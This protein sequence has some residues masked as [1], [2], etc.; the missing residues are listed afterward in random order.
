[1][2]YVSEVAVADSDSETIAQQWTGL[3]G[4]ERVERV[5][6]VGG[7]LKIVKAW[8]EE[9]DE[10]T[11]YLH[12]P[13]TATRWLTIVWSDRPSV[14]NGWPDPLGLNRTRP[15]RTSAAWSRPAA[16]STTSSTKHPTSLAGPE[17]P[18]DKWFL[19][20]RDAFNGVLLWKMPIE[21]MGLARVEAFVVHAA[22]GRDS[23]EPGQAAG[24]GRRQS[25]RHAGLPRTGQRDRRTNGPSAADLRGHGPYIGDPAPR[26][27]AD[28]DGPR[29]RPRRAE[30]IDLESGR[31]AGTSE[32][33]YGG[34]TT[35]Y[36]RFT[37]M[38]GSVPAAKVDP[39]LGHRDRRRVRGPC[40]TATASWASISTARQ[41]W[42][43]AF[44]LVEADHNAGRIA[45]QGKVWNGA[46]I[47]ADGRV[48][49]ASPNML[50]A[51]SADTGEVVWK[52]PKK[53]LQHLWYEWKDVFVID[54]LVWTWSAELAEANSKAAGNSTWPVSLNGYDLHS[55]ELQR[56]VPLGNIFKTHHHHRCYRN[57][58][59]VRYVIASRRGTE[60]VD[61]SGGEHS[62]NNWVRGTC[63]MGMMPA[64]GL[65]YAPPHPCQCYIDEKL[66]GFNALAGGAGASDDRTPEMPA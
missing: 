58:A 21:A 63:H 27:L 11:H 24:G 51:F 65:Q 42:R 32:Q 33:D 34:T 3:A 4:V 53:F 43:T 10:W 36:Y 29:G 17:S 30:A 44:P 22:A 55:G 37:A 31:Q 1:M 46:L 52:Q 16:A 20:A 49:H 9:I 15:I 13:R 60:F 40:W 66:N 54:G 19:A 26:R 2:A 64:N 8:P 59:T 38:R 23:A 45:A 25:V 28:A 6:V 50:A 18:P 48:V 14:I 5:D 57:K 35:D 62:V 39:T 7:W 12:G 41:R 56:E 61:I 47:V